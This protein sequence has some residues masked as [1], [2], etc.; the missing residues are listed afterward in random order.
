MKTRPHLIPALVV[1]GMLLVAVAPLPYGYYQFLRWVTC[2]VSVFIAVESYR[3]KKTW[4]I[5]LF[6]AIAVLF[7]PIFPIYLSKEIWQPIDLT[8]A[9]AFGLGMLFVHEPAKTPQHG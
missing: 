3:W 9:L 2:G 5:W 8:S 6:A 4:A 1:A 7:N